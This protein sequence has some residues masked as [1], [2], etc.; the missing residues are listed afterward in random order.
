M[1]KIIKENLLKALPQ[2][3]QDIIL[4][5]CSIFE[6]NNYECYLVGGVVRDLFRGKESKDVDFT[7]NAPPHIVQKIFR[8]TIPTGIKH[9]TI[10][11]L[12]NQEAFEITTYRSE[13]KYKDARRPDSIT[14]RSSLLEDLSRRD[15]TINALAYDPLKKELV[16]AFN[17][18]K[19]LAEKKICTIGKAE[20]RFCE[21]GLRSIRACRFTASLEYT[22]EENTA[23]A[24]EDVRVQNRTSQVAIE[25]FTEELWKGFSSRKVSAMIEHLEKTKLLFIFL[26]FL[27]AE[28]FSQK[29]NLKKLDAIFPAKPSMRLAYWQ[30]LEKS[31]NEVIDWNLWAKVLKLSKSVNRD[32][33]YYSKYFSLP[34]TIS[35]YSIRFFASEIKKNYNQKAEDFFQNLENFPEKQG[36]NKLLLASYRKYPLLIT[37]LEINGEDLK[38]EGFQ[39][40]EIGEIL[41]KLLDKVLRSPETNKKEKLLKLSSEL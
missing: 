10:T 8:K 40:K 6:K 23:K 15:F 1:K 18:L 2:K 22:L 16:D 27:N 41:Y 14:F 31:K 30:Y 21:D 37:D 4:E 17:G 38:Q 20:E 28:K 25:R 35:S 19:D 33:I 7:T 3:L 13:G 39:G 12:I 24:L 34:Q 36:M 11:V 32:L 29:E 26:P 5:V 9:G